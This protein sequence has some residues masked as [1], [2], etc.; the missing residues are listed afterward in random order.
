MAFSKPIRKKPKVNTV[1]VLCEPS[2]S[3]VTCVP[4]PSNSRARVA[5]AKILADNRYRRW[6][7]SHRIDIPII[8]LRVIMP[9]E[10]LVLF[11]NSDWMEWKHVRRQRWFCLFKLVEE[12]LA[13]KG[14]SYGNKITCTV[15]LT[16]VCSQRLCGDRSS[17]SAWY[18]GF[19]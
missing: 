12:R 18:S 5:Q 19:N 15:L 4:G 8:K 3:G 11:S 17:T 7:I 13:L 14:K 16:L 10:W 2:N 1:G 9:L 6:T